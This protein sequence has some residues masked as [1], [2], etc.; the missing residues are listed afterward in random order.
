M[1]EITGDL[2]DSGSYK[3]DGKAIKLKP[4]ALCITT[5]LYVKGSGC[6]VMGCWTAKRA[7]L[8]DPGLPARLGSIIL[9]GEVGPVVCSRFGGVPIVAFP[10]KPPHGICDRLKANVVKHMRY[11]YSPGQR[12]PGW[13]CTAD[14]WLIQQSCT[15][16]VGLTN[17]YRWDVVILP[18]PGCGAG[19]LLWKDASQICYPILDNR[20]YVITL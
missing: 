19:G 13:A 11:A 10:V 3:R 20:F 4:G 8:F 17:K 7:A 1:I 12:V 2:F 5:N 9:S 18:R 15:S 6:A 16:L 14:R